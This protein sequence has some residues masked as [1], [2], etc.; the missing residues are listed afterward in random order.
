MNPTMPAQAQ[1][2]MG[3]G[4]GGMGGGFGVG[5]FGGGGMGGGGFGDKTTTTT[6]GRTSVKAST[7]RHNTAKAV[8]T[9]VA[10]SPRGYVC[11]RTRDAQLPPRLQL[12]NGAASSRGGGG[13]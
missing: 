2:M 8:I 13:A 7:L 1:Q 3:G 10:A 12:R 9:L 11:R 4:F 5:G 6:P